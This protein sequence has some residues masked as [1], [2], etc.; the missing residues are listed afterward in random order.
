MEGTLHLYR[1]YLLG[2]GVRVANVVYKAH[3]AHSK[4][5]GGKRMKNTCGRELL[6]SSLGLLSA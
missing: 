4:D 3:D 6:V 5:I 2:N 1:V